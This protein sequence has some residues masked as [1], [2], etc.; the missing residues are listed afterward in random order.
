MKANPNVK[1][2]KD[3]RNGATEPYCPTYGVMTIEAVDA[4]T[5][6]KIPNLSY[7]WSGESVNVNE[8]IEDTSFISIIPTLCDHIYTANV[9]VID[10]IYGCVGDASISV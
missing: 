7:T 6:T 10:T 2:V 9:H 3:I 5:G 8:S 4:V 1:I